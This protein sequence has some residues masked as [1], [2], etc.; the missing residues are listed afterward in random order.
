MSV[1]LTGGCGYIGSHTAAVLLEQDYDVVLADDFSNCAEDVPERIEKITGRKPAVYRMNVCDTAALN[2]LFSENSIE[3]VI[4]F[5]AF[6]AVG[7][8]VSRPLEY[9]RNNIDSTLALLSVM[10]EHNCRVLVFSSSATVYGDDKPMPLTESTA[11]TDS[12][13]PYGR[14]KIM[15]ERI[16]ED[17]SKTYG[18]SAVLLRYFNPVGAHPSGLIGEAP[19]GIPGNLMPFICQTAAG[20]RDK[21]MVFGNDYPTPDGTGVRDYIHIM[22]LAEGHVKALE[23]AVDKSGCTAVNLGTGKGTTV[24][25]LVKCF[26]ETTGCSVPY[27]ITARRSGDVTEYLADP[28]LAEKLMGWKSCR[29]LEDMCRD[30]WNWQKR[31]M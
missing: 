26:E 15:N 13:N 6:K 28:S 21:L 20:I 17:V 23:Y 11:V 1:L 8:S 5:A 4:H 27:E 19:D 2:E 14:S 24:L 10:H 9:Y 25:E 29:D 31:T 30:A 7:E 12:T 3:A 16:I 22:D 18:L